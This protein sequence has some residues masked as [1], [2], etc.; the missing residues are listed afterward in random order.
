MDEP[1][2][3]E[4]DG[5]YKR[6]SFVPEIGAFYFKKNTKAVDFKDLANSGH[7]WK[8]ILKGRGFPVIFEGENEI[9]DVR[10]RSHGP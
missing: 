9:K 8:Y 7:A 4:D 6:G 2:A 3:K 5:S 10:I 1:V